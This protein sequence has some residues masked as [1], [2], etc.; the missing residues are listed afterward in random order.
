MLDNELDVS[1]KPELQLHL[2]T[3]AACESYHRRQ[4]KLRDLLSQG[5]RDEFPEWLHQRIMYQVKEHERE[6]IGFARRWKLQTIPAALAVVLSLYVGSL[7]GVKAYN[8]SN[9]SN[10]A[11][12]IQTTEST[13]L[14]S[15]G[16]TSLIEVVATGG[17]Y[18]E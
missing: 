1:R 5:P 8:T 10:T 7:V 6:R 12:T 11:T 16:E 13:E 9:T 4:I 14:A 15:F 18:Y 2:D 17:D 3:C